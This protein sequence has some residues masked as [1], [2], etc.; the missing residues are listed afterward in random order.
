MHF[1][2][3]DGRVILSQDGFPGVKFNQG[4][5]LMEKAERE[6][7]PLTECTRSAIRG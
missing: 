5:P 6:S 7:V 1:I 4:L 3:K 2:T